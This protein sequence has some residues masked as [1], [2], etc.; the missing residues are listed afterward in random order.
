M[1]NRICDH[2]TCHI[3]CP[4]FRGHTPTEIGCEGIT[5]TSQL[6]LI[7]VNRKAKEQHEDIFCMSLP[8]HSKCEIFRAVHEQ[9]EED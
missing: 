7:F 4:Y 3:V 9:Y 2:R 5:P 8:N 1:R 6:K